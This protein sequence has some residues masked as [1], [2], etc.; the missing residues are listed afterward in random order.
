MSTKTLRLA[1]LVSGLLV[2]SIL[3]LIGIHMQAAALD[4][5][6]QTSPDTPDD[7]FET[8]V[9]A[10]NNG[11]TGVLRGVYT[12]SIMALE[13]VP[14][15]ENDP[16]FVSTADNV[17]TE[18]SQANENGITGLLA[19]NTLAG[20]YFS[21]LAPGS[22]I[23]LVYGDSTIE[24]FTVT[25]IYRYQALTPNDP[26]SDF[27]D[28]D[29]GEWISVDTLFIRMYTGA[30][31]LTFQTCILAEGDPSWGRLFIIAEPMTSP[32]AP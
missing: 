25:E 22:I 17:V 14:Q 27:L 16:G 32:E 26:R 11:E 28:L 2:T 29:T 15:P 23:R 4:V 13:I 30:T 7:E 6:S 3:L 21:E 18:F 20:K 10:L 12:P 8:F 5:V 31:H 9:E 24:E 19:H 1:I